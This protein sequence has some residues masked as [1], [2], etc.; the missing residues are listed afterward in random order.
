L[1]APS[2]NASGNGCSQTGSSRGVGVPLG[3]EA[4]Y[5]QTEAISLAFVPVAVATFIR[6]A[7][8]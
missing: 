6:Q 4:R 5:E 2:R 8:Q 7:L 1:V 3:P